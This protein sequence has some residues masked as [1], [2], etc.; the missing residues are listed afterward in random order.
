M[1]QEAEK[2]VSDHQ[3]ATGIY[4]WIIYVMHTQDADAGVV[5]CYIG[6]SETVGKGSWSTAR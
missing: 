4:D 6:K 5:P 2:V 3:A 1:R